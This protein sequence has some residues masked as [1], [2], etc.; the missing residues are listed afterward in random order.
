MNTLEHLFNKIEN[1]KALDFGIIIDEVITLYKMVW[2]KGAVL[3]LLM[4]VCGAAVAVVFTIIGLAP[5]SEIFVNG[6]FD[7]E[8]FVNSYSKNALYSVPQNILMSTLTM[9]FLAAFYR[10]CSFELLGKPYQNDYFYFFRNGYFSKLLTLGMIY[11]G[12]ST[13]AQLLFLIPLI[14]VY[15]PLSYIAVIF[16][17]NPDL[18]EIEIVKASFK[19]GNKKW[20]ISF[21]TMFVGA[22]MGM[23]GIL[24]CGIGVIFT[25][26]IAYLPVLFIYKEVIGFEYQS[27]IDEIGSTF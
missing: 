12:I 3:F 6:E 14:Y 27:P 24:G 20:L 23:L 1:A 10:M 11:T 5:T 7:I 19:L 2:Q 15:V 4:M 8:G 13:I 17:F 21:G 22:L 16:A 18:T 25:I 26:A 9:A